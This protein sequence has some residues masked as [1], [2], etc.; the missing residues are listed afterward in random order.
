MTACSGVVELAPKDPGT[1]E[2]RDSRLTSSE[3]NTPTRLAARFETSLS[4]QSA[5]RH[6]E[7]GM[8]G[9]PG[10]LDRASE[11]SRC[12]HGVYTHQRALPRCLRSARFMVGRHGLEPY[13]RVL[14]RTLAQVL[15]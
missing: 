8:V 14:M 4:S 7:P 10:C 13:S 2:A 1:R 9:S 3:Q 6:L 11:A 12:L 5:R 15:T